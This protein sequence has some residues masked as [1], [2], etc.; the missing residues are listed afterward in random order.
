MNLYDLSQE[1]LKRAKEEKPQ[2]RF[3]IDEQ[4]SETRV[5]VGVRISWDDNGLRLHGRPLGK[6]LMNDDGTINSIQ[7]DRHTEYPFVKRLEDI[8]RDAGISTYLAFDANRGEE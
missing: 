1:L 8:A 4:S 6:A 7:L 2:V 5:A 3:L